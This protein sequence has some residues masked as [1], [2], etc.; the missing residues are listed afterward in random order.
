MKGGNFGNNIGAISIV[1]F[2]IILVIII[3]VVIASKQTDGFIVL[4]DDHTPIPSDCPEYLY[5]DG[6]H[7]YAH[8]SR[9]PIDGEKNPM[10]FDTLE[11]AKAYMK[12]KKCSL[13]IPVNNL[14][15]NKT[16]KD[17]TD[18]YEYECAR[19]I[20][21][22]IQSA[23]KCMYYS[24]DLD[25]VRKIQNSLDDPATFTNYDLETCIVD[26][27]GKDANFNPR[28]TNEPYQSI[29]SSFNTTEFYPSA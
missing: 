22:Y 14:V 23:E 7:Y 12:E 15:V 2:I 3:V 24:K 27:V 26:L 6:K 17:P 11:G 21:P 25:E 28:G 4:V 13:D 16:G 9:K 29:F 8:N 1:V 20:A 10:K 19:K 18:I 5:T